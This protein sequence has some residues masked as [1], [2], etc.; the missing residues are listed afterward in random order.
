MHGLVDTDMENYRRIGD[1]EPR[2]VHKY[3]RG[4]LVT[5]EGCGDMVIWGRDG[6][7]RYGLGPWV[8]QYIVCPLKSDLKTP[9]LR[10]WNSQYYSRSRMKRVKESEL[11]LVKSNWYVDKQ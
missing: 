11:T 9:D 10:S 6:V 2:P 3:H 7:V 5:V 8:C 4:D 1:D